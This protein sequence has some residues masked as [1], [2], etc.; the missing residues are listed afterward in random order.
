[1]HFF[2]ILQFMHIG[3]S[4][5]TNSGKQPIFASKTALLPDLSR[6]NGLGQLFSPRFSRRLRPQRTPFWPPG[7]AVPQMP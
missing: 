3:E 4:V 6:K 2:N 1:M 5:N 7:T